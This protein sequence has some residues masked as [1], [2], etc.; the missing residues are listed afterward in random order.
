MNKI[1][2]EV[3][4]LPLEIQDMFDNKYISIENLVYTIEE[5]N[6]ELNHVK[7]EFENYKQYVNDNY[8]IISQAEQI[9]YDERTW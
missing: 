7:E 6:Y 5:L 2:I 9:D 4:D 3:Y 8:K 1:Y